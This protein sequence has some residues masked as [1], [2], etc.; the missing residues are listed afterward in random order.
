[1]P[2]LLV[3]WSRQASAPFLSLSCTVRLGCI[4]FAFLT[5]CRQED[6]DVVRLGLN[7]AFNTAINCHVESGTI[8]AEG[9]IPEPSTPHIGKGVALVAWQQPLCT[10]VYIDALPSQI[11]QMITHIST[12]H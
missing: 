5:E 12:Q 3:P 10:P 6:M 9:T 11:A 7:E 4:L 2:N 8:F 1:M